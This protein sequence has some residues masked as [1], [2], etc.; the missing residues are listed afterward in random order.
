MT[1]DTSRIIA[2]QDKCC[3]RLKAA[4]PLL[5]RR[6]SGPALAGGCA[7]HPRSLRT[8]R[9]TSPASIAGAHG[10]ETEASPARA[11]FAR[12]LTRKTSS[13]T[14]SADTGSGMARV[15]GADT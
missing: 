6:D 8:A 4:V 7:A 10:A 1:Q 2:A 14:A 3:L 9:R 12:V 11:R 15:I 13:R 5:P